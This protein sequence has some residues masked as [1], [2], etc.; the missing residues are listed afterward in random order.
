MEKIEGKSEEL[1]KE[2]HNL[3]LQANRESVKYRLFEEDLEPMLNVAKTLC[4][5]LHKKPIVDW[6]N[7]DKN[8]SDAISQKMYARDCD[9][10]SIIKLI[11]DTFFLTDDGRC[12]ISDEAANIAHWV[13]FHGY[14]GCSFTCKAAGFRFKDM[15]V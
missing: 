4:D 7:L 6:D 15:G 14:S 12:F 3:R 1:E 5:I 13:D 2:L 8:T 11:M 9:V 10:V